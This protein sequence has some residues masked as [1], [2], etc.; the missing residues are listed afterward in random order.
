MGAGCD[1]GKCFIAVSLATTGTLWY[2]ESVFGVNV[3]VQ[4]LPGTELKFS[5]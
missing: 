3:R 1:T 2:G 4:Y 5:S